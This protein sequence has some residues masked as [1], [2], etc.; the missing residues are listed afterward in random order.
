MYVCVCVCVCVCVW[1]CVYCRIVYL[2]VCLGSKHVPVGPLTPE[3]E[4]L[5]LS[6]SMVAGEG[7]EGEREDKS[8]TTNV[9]G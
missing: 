5:A 8:P 7:E 6:A 1:V 4:I 2:Q 3:Q 9:K